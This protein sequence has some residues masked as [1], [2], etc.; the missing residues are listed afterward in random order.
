M[1]LYVTYATYNT[2]GVKGLLTNPQDRAIVIGKLAEKAGGKLVALYYT[3][4][5]NDIVCITELPNEDAAVALGMAVSS[6]GSIAKLD[7]VR[8]W[9]SGQFVDVAKMAGGYSELYTPPGG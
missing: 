8:A 5:P 6:G 9:T 7:T 3:T 4:G 2:T 1:Q